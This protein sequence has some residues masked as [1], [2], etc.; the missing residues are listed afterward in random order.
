MTRSW[1]AAE[2]GCGTWRLPVVDARHAART[3][4]ASISDPCGRYR[5]PS[6]LPERNENGPV[7]RAVSWI[8]RSARLRCE[9]RAH[10]LQRVGL[11]LADAF[12]ADAV[13]VC[14]FLQRDLALRVQPAALDDVARTL[15]QAGQA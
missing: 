15:V 8:E 2:R 4:S 7:S 6:S 10:L 9:Q 12:G 11:D 14:Q 13:F 5:T 1:R 3:R